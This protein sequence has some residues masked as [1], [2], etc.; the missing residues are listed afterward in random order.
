MGDGKVGYSKDKSLYT[1]NAF[2]PRAAVSGKINNQ[3]VTGHSFV[4]R[5]A[6]NVPLHQVCTSSTHF[7][8]HTPEFTFHFIQMYVKQGGER[9]SFSY[10]SF[11]QGK[12]LVAV[13]VD[14]D[15]KIVKGA[16][17]S[18]SGYRPPESMVFEWKGK[19]LDGRKSFEATARV[20]AAPPNLPV[21]DVLANIPR[22]LRWVVQKLFAKPYMY[23]Y[24]KPAKV[25]VNVGGR[26][27][28]VAGTALFENHFINPD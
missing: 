19:T 3:T 14:N 2:F 6:V 9:L 20:D 25:E 22:V 11:V 21:I 5:N 17:D 15:C 26:R 1:F 10:G 8:L 13:T 12:Q 27:F 24:M 16:K 28:D 7:K 4:G 23:Q 18:F